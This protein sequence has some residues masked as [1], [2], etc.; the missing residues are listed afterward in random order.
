MRIHP[1]SLSAWFCFLAS[2]LFAHSALAEPFGCR[3]TAVLS[4][5]TLTCL[6]DTRIEETIRLGNIE[7]PAVSQPFGQRAR[8][9]LAALTLGKPVTVRE[10]RR[11]A[12]KRIVGTLWVTPADCPG[13]GH[14]L[15]S[16][17]AQL[18]LGLARYSWQHADAQAEQEREQ[19]RFEENE[20][21]ARK[22]GLWGDTR[23]TPPAQGRGPLE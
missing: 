18:S 22:I 5:D 4:G 9:S 6:T 19:Y 8:R 2:L 15:D 13:C 7:A 20:A 3:V 11:D 16:A 17:A 10:G 14:T 1:P 21:R 12:L 23:R